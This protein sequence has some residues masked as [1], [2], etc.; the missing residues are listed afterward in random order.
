MRLQH[1]PSAVRATFDDPNLVSCAGLVPVM[2][3]A[4]S[5]GLHSVVEQE[6]H[7]PGDRTGR[8]SVTRTV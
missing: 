7:L 3:L 4:E 1:R 8:G 2:R 5:A 6:V